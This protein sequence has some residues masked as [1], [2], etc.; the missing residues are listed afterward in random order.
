MPTLRS[1][2]GALVLAPALLL[3]TGCENNEAGVDTKGTTTSPDAVTS[4]DDA[5]KRG[6]QP[7]AKTTAPSSYPGA[8]RRK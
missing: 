7:T 6:A 8:G 2:R 5:V 4:T 3:A 1:L